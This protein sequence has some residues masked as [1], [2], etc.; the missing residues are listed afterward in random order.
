MS[1]LCEA[2]PPPDGLGAHA[3]RR[4]SRRR[5]S[6]ARRAFGDRGTWVLGAPEM[7]WAGRPPD[8][9]VRARADELA[10]QGQRVLLLAHTRRARS[11]ASSCPTGSHAAA[12]VV[13]EEQIRDDAADTLGVLRRARACGA[14]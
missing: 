8:D 4:R 9:P 12:L 3:R 11:S 2:F 14:W 13:F 10:A 7:V 5:A 1:A 6:G